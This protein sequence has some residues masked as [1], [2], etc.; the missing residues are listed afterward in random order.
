[1]EKELDGIEL[2]E[3]PWSGGGAALF[4]TRRDLC[5]LIKS[6]RVRDGIPDGAFAKAL[7]YSVTSGA[8]LRRWFQ[9]DDSD[10]T[11]P[12]LENCYKMVNFI[13]KYYPEIIE[14][15]LPVYFVYEWNFA[16]NGEGK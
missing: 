7:G 6:I 15:S 12:S 5:R 9:E 13:K 2:P 10:W 8:G 4:I 1:M 3:Y 16:D 11:A 14:P